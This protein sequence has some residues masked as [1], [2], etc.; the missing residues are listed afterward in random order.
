VQCKLLE[1]FEDTSQKSNPPKIKDEMPSDPE[2]CYAKSIIVDQT[3]KIE[4]DFSI[5]DGDAEQKD[6]DIEVMQIE[7]SPASTK[8]KK[9]NEEWT[10]VEIPAEYK[11]YNVLLDTTQTSNY[12]IETITTK[13]TII[14]TGGFTEWKEVVCEEDRTDKLIKEIQTALSDKEYSGGLINGIFDDKWNQALVSFQKENELPLGQLDTETLD[15]L[16]VQY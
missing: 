6:V 4:K 10:L 13:T 15:Y 9:Q 7:I 11:T 12:H 5:Y 1:P 16:E 8:W 3:E 2:K 14:S